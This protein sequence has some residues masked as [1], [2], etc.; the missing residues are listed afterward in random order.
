MIHWLFVCSQNKRRSLTAEKIFQRLDGY[1]VRSAGTEANA[2]VK[3][4]PGMLGWADVIYCMEKKHV[5]RLRAAYSDALVGKK[6]ICLHIDDDYGFMDE[7][8]V[9][10]L[11]SSVS[12]EQNSKELYRL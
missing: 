1:T 2:R 5:R 4:T 6:V 10:L 11:E 8:L 3:V 12:N 7:A 9:D